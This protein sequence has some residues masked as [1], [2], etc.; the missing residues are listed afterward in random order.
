MFVY[1]D[2]KYY[3]KEE[4]KI[5]VFDHGFLYGDGVFEG[6][7][8]YN[9]RVFKLEEHVDRLYDSANAIL[10]NI[11]LTKSEIKEAVLET[12]R[13][14]NIKDGYI[15]IVVSRGMGDL[16][17]DP[18]NCEKASIII[19]CDKIKLYP[20]NFYESGLN[21]ISSSI[22][23]NNH[24]SIS[25]RIKSL[26]Y[27][28]HIMA[29]LEAKQAGVVEAVMLNKEGFVCECTGDNIFIVRDGVLITP[30]VYLGLLKGITRDFIIEIAQSLGIKVKEEP[31]SQYE[32]Y[33]AEECFLSGT[34]AEA[35]P[36][37]KIDMR[38]IGNGKPGEITNK[39]IKEFRTRVMNEGTDIF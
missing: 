32:L 34:A 17:L 1:I 23:K 30:P 14:N 13:K 20:Q 28:N 6:I 19:I 16:G 2:G 24:E 11:Y 7:R 33:T 27:L 5:S 15:R 18:Y 26:N 10:L 4:A 35:I 8:A 25:P 3:S 21:I 38:V 29:K 36:V 39:I 31:F 37:V 22:R 12:L 9:G